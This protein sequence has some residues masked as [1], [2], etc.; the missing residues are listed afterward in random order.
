MSRPC[1]R[2]AFSSNTCHLPPVASSELQACRGDLGLT[3]AVSQGVA[4]AVRLFVS[5]AANA[6]ALDSGAVTIPNDWARTME[7]QHNQQL[8]A[9]LHQV[10]EALVQLYR[11]DASRRSTTSARRGDAEIRAALSTTLA[12]VVNEV[13]A[14]IWG[15]LVYTLVLLV[16]TLWGTPSIG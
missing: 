8:V 14:L 13:H 5:K 12:P 15:I 16:P 10:E 2:G 6:A 9:R 3:A 4:T 1:V 7:Q 11:V